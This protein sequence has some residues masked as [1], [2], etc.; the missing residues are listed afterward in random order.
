MSSSGLAIACWRGQRSPPSWNELQALRRSTCS[1][2]TDTFFTSLLPRVSTRA[3]HLARQLTNPS[4]PLLSSPVVSPPGPALLHL[5]PPLTHA[6]SQRFAAV[7]HARHLR[8]RP[9]E[10]A[11][12]ARSRNPQPARPGGVSRTFLPRTSPELGTPADRTNLPFYLTQD[13]FPPPDCGAVPGLGRV[14]G[15]CWAGWRCARGDGRGRRRRGRA[16]VGRGRKHAALSLWHLIKRPKEL[17][18]CL[19]LSRLSRAS[20]RRSCV[21][22]LRSA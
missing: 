20:S 8:P 6:H 22:L 11:H 16:R 19:H 10:G 3:D 18:R 4:S 13:G 7:Q 21:P 9:A 5:V 15:R 17:T 12:R 1:R 14:A 2:T